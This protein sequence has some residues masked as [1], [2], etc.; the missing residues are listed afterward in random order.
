MTIYSA[1]F[2]LEDRELSFSRRRVSLPG[3]ETT[4][5]GELGNSGLG[6]I[7]PLPYGVVLGGLERTFAQKAFLQT[8]AAGNHLIAYE[9]RKAGASVRRT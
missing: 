8:M 6:I 5:C 1:P 3:Q 9:Q 7:F 4:V 2:D